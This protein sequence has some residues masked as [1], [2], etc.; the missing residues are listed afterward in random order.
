LLLLLLLLLAIR[1]PKLAVTVMTHPSGGCWPGRMLLLLL[2]APPRA[3]L[4]RSPALATAANL[5]CGTR[6]DC[7]HSFGDVTEFC[8][9]GQV[10]HVFDGWRALCVGHSFKCMMHNGCM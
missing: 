8:T 2:L 7:H 3:R 10:V 5:A 9:F 6:C 1:L 4:L